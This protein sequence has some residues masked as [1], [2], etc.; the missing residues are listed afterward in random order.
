MNNNKNNRRGQ[1]HHLPQSP[2]V[3]GKYSKMADP[4]PPL[5]D[6]DR[7]VPGTPRLDNH[8]QLIVINPE[9]VPPSRSGRSTGLR[10][11]TS[12]FGLRSLQN[13]RLHHGR[14]SSL[15]EDQTHNLNHAT[16][17]NNGKITIANIAQPERA[18][19]I[20][21]PPQWIDRNIEEI[22]RPRTSPLESSAAGAGGAFFSPPSTSSNNNSEAKHKILRK[23]LTSDQ[24]FNLRHRQRKSTTCIETFIRDGDQLVILDAKKI[25]SPQQ[26]DTIG[27]AVVQD[28]PVGDLEKG[29]SI[30]EESPHA[31]SID[32][33]VMETRGRRAR[34]WQRKGSV[35]LHPGP[36]NS[37][38]P[39]D[40]GDDD[41]SSTPRA[42]TSFTAEMQARLNDIR[43]SL[44]NRIGRPTS[45]WWEDEAG[46]P[47]RSLT[48]PPAPTTTI[49]AIES[50][51]TTDPLTL[52]SVPV[53][54][55]LR[56]SA[57]FEEPE[58]FV[59]QQLADLKSENITLKSLK[60]L[61]G[62]AISTLRE[63]KLTLVQH[64]TALEATISE[65]DIK[66]RAQQA[67][68]DRQ[69]STI[70]KFSRQLSSKDAEQAA[71]VANFSTELA[72]RDNELIALKDEKW[73]L[74]RKITELE[75]MIAE[76]EAQLQQWGRMGRRIPRKL[77]MS[78]TGDAE[79]DVSGAT[80]SP[81]TDA[82]PGDDRVG[83]SGSESQADNS[84]GSTNGLMILDATITGSPKSKTAD[85]GSPNASFSPPFTPC[86]SPSSSFSGWAATT[87][88]RSIR[89]LFNIPSQPTTGVPAQDSIL[90]NSATS[91]SSATRPSSRRRRSLSSQTTA[92]ALAEEDALT[93]SSRPTT[94][95]D[96]SYQRVQPVTAQQK[97][98]ASENLGLERTFIPR[99]NKQVSLNE[100]NILGNAKCMSRMASVEKMI[101]NSPSLPTLPSL[102]TPELPALTYSRS[103]TVWL[104]RVV[105]MFKYLNLSSF[106]RSSDTAT[107][108]TSE[109]LRAA[110]ILKNAVNDDILE[111]VLFLLSREETHSNSAHADSGSSASECP[112]L[113]LSAILTIHGLVSGSPSEVGWVDRISEAELG[114]VEDFASLVLCIDKRRNTIF[115][116]STQHYDCVLPKIQE[117]VNQRVPEMDNTL[118]SDA[119]GGPWPKKKSPLSTWMGGLVK[120]RQTRLESERFEV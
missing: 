110:I 108:D 82:N 48:P 38:P 56:A 117:G 81:G 41:T 73:N 94:G 71:L 107:A 55:V 32:E 85:M 25:S 44:I 28:R 52:S 115:G 17:N 11:A 80:Y 118:H 99:L 22:P 50:A 21:S 46:R 95:Q 47:R 76:T 2:L 33:I 14:K 106:L 103:L 86:A 45:R 74:Q 34:E 8:S 68:M 13:L 6:A 84:G 96:L 72:S 7:F 63:E 27:T 65:S 91:V 87:S 15:Y 60:K 37:N 112:H 70:S 93:T 78:S 24:L 88:P 116:G 18:H 62:E 98:L 104:D 9:A 102:S 100:L 49:K 19:V 77:R 114:G 1:A 12:M 29:E 31:A 20:L 111:D 23:S 120:R 16:T 30:D 75:Q 51:A 61:Q 42:T 5:A 67:T 97:A 101:Q 58:L 92:V 83:Q 89:P 57:L 113:L 26:I 69:N 40:N 4:L 36:L 79:G 105:T 39:R 3:G 53:T 43:G 109:R 10:H 119:A 90:L 66:I 35:H 54:P 64:K 59:H